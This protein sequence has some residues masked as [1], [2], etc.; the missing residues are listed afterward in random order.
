MDCVGCE[1]C[2]L[3]G[4]LQ[5]LGLGTALNILFSVDGQN[6]PA[7]PVSLCATFFLWF[8]KYFL[9]KFPNILVIQ[10]FETYGMCELMTLP[11]NF[12][13]LLV[14]QLQLHRNEVIALLN[15]LNRLSESIKFVHEKGPSVERIM[16]ERPLEPS[17]QELGLW[18][19]LW[20][21]VV[22]QSSSGT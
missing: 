17:A 18:R 12:F 3:W 22:E 8:P 2:R 19:R 7:Q 1:K 21:S 13:V 16:K 9:A 4:K 10:I 20:E 6:N 14:L 11:L 15:L 5:V